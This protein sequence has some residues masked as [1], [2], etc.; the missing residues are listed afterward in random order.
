MTRDGGMVIAGD[1]DYAR[2]ICK[3]AVCGYRILC[4]SGFDER[5]DWSYQRHGYID[6]LGATIR[7]FAGSNS[8]ASP[9][10]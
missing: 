7:Y 6:A 10:V 4:Q 5:Y 3:A 9:T 2:D 1:E 8:I